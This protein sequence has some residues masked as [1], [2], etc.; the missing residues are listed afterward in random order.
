[1]ERSEWRKVNNYCCYSAICSFSISCRQCLHVKQTSTAHSTRYRL[2]SYLTRAVAI[3]PGEPHSATKPVHHHTQRTRGLFVGAT[4]GRRRELPGRLRSGRESGDDQ[5]NCRGDWSASGGSQEDGSD[6]QRGP[7]ALPASR[8]PRLAALFHPERLEQDQPD[9]PVFAQGTERVLWLLSRSALCQWADWEHVSQSQDGDVIRRR[10][11]RRTG[12]TPSWTLWL[13]K[14]L[15]ISLALAAIPSRLVG[16][17]TLR[18]DIYAVMTKSFPVPHGWEEQERPGHGSSS[19]PRYRMSSFR[20]KHKT[21][22]CAGG[23]LWDD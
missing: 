12:K 2:L 20:M 10:L 22:P 18:R 23:K 13:Y 15:F 21:Q 7:R 14:A 9:L 11:P 5:A 19:L 4:F 17:Q 6:D 1:M 8:S 3:Y 16:S